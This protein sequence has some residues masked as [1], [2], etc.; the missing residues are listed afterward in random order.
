MPFL[1]RGRQAKETLRAMLLVQMKERDDLTTDLLRSVIR[2]GTV[3]GDSLICVF[4]AL[5]P[6][7]CRGGPIA[8]HFDST[9]V[10]VNT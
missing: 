4:V 2:L 1:I 8:G 5:Q 10:N 6:I 7:R 3:L 9:A